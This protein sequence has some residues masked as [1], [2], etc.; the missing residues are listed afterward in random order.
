L[1]C[2]WG[3]PANILDFWFYIEKP[4]ENEKRNA[5]E[6]KKCLN[7]GCSPSIG[8]SAGPKASI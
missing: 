6:N 5:K 1:V 3:I 2:K 4:F 8:D 7:C